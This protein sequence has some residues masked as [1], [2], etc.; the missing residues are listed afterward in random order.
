[1]S[2]PF[3]GV[4]RNDKGD[5]EHQISVDQPTKRGLPKIRVW[6]CWSVRDGGWVPSVRVSAIRHVRQSTTQVLE[7]TE[8]QP[9]FHDCELLVV[10]GCQVRDKTCRGTACPMAI[11]GAQ[12]RARVEKGLPDGV[13]GQ[14]AKQQGKDGCQASPF[15][16]LL[17]FPFL[18]PVLRMGVG[19]ILIVAFVW[20]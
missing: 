17:S 13:I 19:R 8:Q 9:W 16:S 18:D 2:D 7:K 12:L 11:N 20:P 4:R 14:R 5:G 3:G 6:R 10:K 1:M 15:S